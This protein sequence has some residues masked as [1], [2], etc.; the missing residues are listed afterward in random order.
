MP[1]E[2]HASGDA[3]ERNTGGVPAGKRSYPRQEGMSGLLRC[4][5]KP[6]PLFLG[7]TS[8][9]SSTIIW[10]RADAHRQSIQIPV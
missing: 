6:T 9:T 1:L 4:R 8:T 3:G 7:I 10:A 2:S 5:S